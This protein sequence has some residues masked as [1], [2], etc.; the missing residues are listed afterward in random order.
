MR[1]LGLIVVGMFALATSI[2]GH[3]APSGSLAPGAW[4]LEPVERRMGSPALRA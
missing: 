4:P 1:A 2:A 3:A